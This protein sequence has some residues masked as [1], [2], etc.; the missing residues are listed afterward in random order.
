VIG[1]KTHAK[2]IRRKEIKEVVGQALPAETLFLV[3]KL[4]LGNALIP[5]LCFE[6][7]IVDNLTDNALSSLLRREE[8]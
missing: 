2:A 7:R 1:R 6:I 8:K 3:P 5:K 4:Q